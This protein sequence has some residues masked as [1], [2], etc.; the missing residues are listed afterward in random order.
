MNRIETRGRKPKYNVLE[1]LRDIHR[2]RALTIGQI[3]EVFF[4][5]RKPYV[6]KK[7]RLLKKEGL[8]SDMPHSEKDGRIIE[9]LYYVTETGMD[10][11]EREGCLVGERRPQRF[12]KP[13][14]EKID[15][16][17]L[18]NDIYVLL[19]QHGIYMIDSRQWKKDQ[20]ID[21]NT[22]V[23]GG[24]VL[25][26]RK[27]YGLYAFFNETGEKGVKNAG[28]GSEEEHSIGQKTIKRFLKEIENLGNTHR[29]ICM[30]YGQ[31]MYEQLEEA[32]KANNPGVLEMNL[33]PYG[34]DGVGYKIICAYNGLEAQKNRFY[35]ISGIKP[36]NEE[37]NAHNNEFQH[38]FSYIGQDSMGEEVY[39]VDYLLMNVIAIQAL[40]KLYAVDKYL[41][42]GRSVVIFCW[43]P[44]LDFLKK[45]FEA[46]PHIKII[47]VAIELAEKWSEEKR[48]GSKQEEDIIFTL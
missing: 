37:S 2:M 39:V 40:Y 7:L 45:T 31:H 41:E 47:P 46:Y 38:F 17:V 43:Q 3:A 48:V 33:I 18:T 6:Y 16:L 4:G 35:E 20:G 10:L 1:M 28:N 14:K 19:K 32:I 23:R 8:I 42:D 36:L 5:G 22:M 11:L 30:I 26:D 27:P 21:R 25:D 34:R 24:I 12:N 29:Y 9:K 15:Y 44:T 13:K